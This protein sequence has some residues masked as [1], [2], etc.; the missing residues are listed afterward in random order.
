MAH[1]NKYTE[2]RSHIEFKKK[3]KIRSMNFRSNNYNIIT[4]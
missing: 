4:M 3:Y 2:H 1:L